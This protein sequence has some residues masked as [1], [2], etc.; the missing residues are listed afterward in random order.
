M[1]ATILKSRVVQ[2]AQSHFGLGIDTS[3]VE[4]YLVGDLNSTQNAALQAIN[5]PG[6]PRRGDLHPDDG[7]LSLQGMDVRPV[8]NSRTRVWVLATY[9]PLDFDPINRPLI[10]FRAT[11]KQVQRV[12]D[13]N[14]NPIKINYTDPNNNVYPEWTGQIVDTVATGI[15]HAEWVEYD[16]PSTRLL[17]FTNGLNNSSYKGGAKYTWWIA[18]IDIT[19]VAYQSG[20]K[21]IAELYYDPETWIQTIPYRDKFG[22]IPKDID[23]A[24]SRNKD[25]GSYQGY[26]RG[27]IKNVISFSGLNIPNVQ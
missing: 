3:L 12:Y 17:P 1:P 26:V 13:N 25:P 5:A 16:D 21:I 27:T 2:W 23:L 22:I 24:G 18:S 9:R 20:Y 15:L 10:E 4:G 6:I 14:G 8:K 19:K 11:T 7:Q